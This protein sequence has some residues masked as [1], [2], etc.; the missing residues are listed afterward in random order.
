MLGTVAANQADMISKWRHVYG[1]RHHGAKLTDAQ[2][3]AIRARHAA[4]GVSY[5]HLARCYAV[6]EGTIRE[7][8]ARRGW[9]HVA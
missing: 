4:G 2:V 9:R 5:A 7:V 6:T 1:E 8:V 3:V